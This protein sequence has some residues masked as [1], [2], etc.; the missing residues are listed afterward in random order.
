MSVGG[1]MS[2]VKPYLL[3]IF[4]QIGFAG[5]YTIAVASLKRGM[6]HY[7]LVVY[8]NGIAAAVMAPFAL[9][10]ERKTRPKMTLRVFLKIITLGLLEPVLD[11]NLSYMGQNNTSA[12]FGSTLFNTIPAITF[13][14]AVIFRMEKVNLKH[15]RSQAKVIGTVV[16][17]L[18]ALLMIFYDGPVVEFFW[19]KGRTHHSTSGA[20]NGGGNWVSG[21]IMLLASC[22]FWSGFYIVQANTLESYPAELSLT[23]LICFSGSVLSSAVTIIMEGWT[24]KPWSIGFDMRL[25]TVIYSGVI[26]SGVAYYVQ[27]IVMKERGPVFVTSF[28]PLCM[29]VTTLLGSI[30]LAEEITLGRILGAVVIVSGLYS[31][32]WGKGNDHLTVPS[33]KS[34]KNNG[35]MDLPTTAAVTVSQS[36]LE[37]QVK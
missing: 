12:G 2:K 10:F 16:S 29:I 26:C 35:S 30:I 28:N 4:L 33:D 15:R 31:L 36:K 8:R 17:V 6:N 24:A 7:V 1:V 14:M 18:G 34:G 9:W 3:V 25:I 32:I 5:M 19:S 27:G 22:V 20:N 21:T 11:Q 13:V 23:T 37:L